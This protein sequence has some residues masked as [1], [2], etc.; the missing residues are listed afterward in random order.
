LPKG[1]VIPLRYTGQEPLNLPPGNNWQEV[2]VVT[3]DV[4]NSFNQV[5]IPAGSQ[6]IGHFETDFRGSRFVTQ[7]ISLPNQNLMF[8]ARSTSI[9]GD[10]KPSLGNIVA[11]SGA[12]A[13]AGVLIGGPI[14][15]IGGVALGAA[16]GYFTSPQPAVIQPNQIIEVHLSEDWK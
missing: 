7:A 13:V 16:S 15:M 4:L 12:G 8:P 2:L 14:G 3:Q 6:V 1:T 10:R 9:D 11:G 5:I